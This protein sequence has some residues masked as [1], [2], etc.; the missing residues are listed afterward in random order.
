MRH[1][2]ETFE[3]ELKT[4]SNLISEHQIEEIDLLKIDCEGA[5]YDCL[6]GIGQDDWQKV[7][8]VV[9]EVHDIDDGL[10]Q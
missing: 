6:I 1:S 8:Q 2:A 5:E 10:A 3:C 9:V 7:K 4:I